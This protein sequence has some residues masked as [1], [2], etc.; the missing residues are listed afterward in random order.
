LFDVTVIDYGVGNLLSVQRG[1]EKCG[2]S[3]QL[4]SDAETILKAKRV[5]LPGVGAFANAIDAL[6]NYGLQPVI[7]EIAKRGH[8]L[9]GICLGMELLFEE[10]NE[11]GHTKGLGLIPGYVTEIPRTSLAGEVLK[12]PHI[13]WNSINPPTNI[14]KWENSIL[15]KNKLGDSMYFVHSFMAVPTDPKDRLAD[16]LY[17]GHSISAVV[18]KNRITGCQF[19]PEKSGESGLRILREFA[20]CK[21]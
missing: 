8:P 16:C 2:A 4:V 13:G 17:G 5:V 19:H 6:N 11:F 9:L 7:Q 1:F 21:I 12:I 14:S 3:V 18:S 20:F 15:R 10:S